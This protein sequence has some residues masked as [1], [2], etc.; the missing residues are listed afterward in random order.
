MRL[1]RSSLFSVVNRDVKSYA[2]DH[3][4]R[5]S[6]EHVAKAAR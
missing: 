1:T 2:I 5:Y 4:Y 3:R 6:V